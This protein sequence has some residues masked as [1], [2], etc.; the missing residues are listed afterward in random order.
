MNRREIIQTVDLLNVARDAYYNTG[1]TIMTDKEYDDRL[2]ELANAQKEL[3]FYPTNSPVGKVG[4]EVRDNGL[5]KVT[6]ELRARS[7]DKT[8]D[9]KQVVAK[10]TNAS[11]CKSVV[12]WKLD[13]CTLVLTYVNGDLV[14]AA[15]RGDGEIG[16]DITRN[17]KYIA[18]IPQHIDMNTG[19]LIVRGECLISYSDFE[20]INDSLPA[21]VTHYANPRN[22]ASASVCVIDPEDIKDRHLTF[23]AF[24]L[25]VIEGESKVLN[26]DNLIDQFIYL[27][28]NGFDVVPHTICNVNE[29]DIKSTIDLFTSGLNKYAYAVDG[30]VFALNDRSL[31]RGLSGTEHHPDPKYGYAFKWA[32]EEV[33]TILRNIEW[34]P[35]RT[36][37]LNPVAVFDPVEIAGTTVSRA[38][39]HNINYILDKK[40][41]VNDRITVFKAN[42]I[43]PQIGK[44]LT[45]EDANRENEHNMC[46]ISDLDE[47]TYIY[48]MLPKTCPT[49]GHA[50]E[51]SDN[52]GVLT[53][54]CT[55]PSCPEKL[56]GN[57]VHFCSREGL[58]IEGW[59]EETIK[60]LHAV[61][62]IN[63]FKDIFLLKDNPAMSF[64]P[65]FGKKSWMNLCESAEK[66]RKTTFVKFVS[67]LSIPN[68][69][70][71]QAKILKKFIDD[72][73]EE[74]S[75]RYQI[76]EYD[77]FRVLVEMGLHLFDFTQ[78]K[79]VGPK[80]TADLIT[81]M[82]HNFGAKES[83]YKRLM[84][85]ITFIDLAPISND[86]MN[87]P[88]NS[89]V[90][91]K[92]FCITGK[93]IHH[94][95]RE[96]LVTEIENNGGKWIDSVSSKTDYLIN[97]DTESTSGKNKKAKEL[98]IPIIS[99]ESFLNMIN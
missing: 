70:K 51:V 81:F 29:E 49:C 58:D 5:T 6:H 57:L 63:E 44:N 67:A 21:G 22:L 89:K 73:Y 8:K 98:G 94:A 82:H 87:P 35:S 61:H 39:L 25:N 96:E 42:M 3:N 75:D 60:K 27:G 18:D 20:K 30:L 76:S 84:K 88:M 41:K 99:E 1:Q 23:K 19:K 43:V 36:G 55:N 86:F 56:I 62:I 64:M 7:L 32:D 93:L 78:I 68:V 4:A 97:N 45:E 59:S 12:M 80:L 83:P 17:T 48:S 46:A 13:G 15:T 40:L 95:N 14:L 31:S 91:G 16:Q 69:G 74:L 28:D 37:L 52:S 71:G 38:S 33:E 85:Y 65:G 90:A 72:N 34:S 9:Y 26:P 47:R 10:L 24:D 50:T 92:T 53:L 77:P 66:A 54:V 11:H 79:G 2:A